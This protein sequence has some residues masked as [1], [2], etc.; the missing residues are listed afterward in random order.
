VLEGN[1]LGDSAD[2]PSGTA[3]L[4]PSG[5]CGVE[6]RGNEFA[7]RGLRVM[8][9]GEGT[10]RIYLSGNTAEGQALGRERVEDNSGRV[11]F[12]EPE[13]PL[14]VGPAAAKQAD[15]RHLSRR[16]PPQPPNF[17]L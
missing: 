14:S 9:V 7:C 8:R 4:I 13:S 16:L 5:I 3:V 11:Q 10:R 1:C 17:N 6:L 12:S 2:D 15:T